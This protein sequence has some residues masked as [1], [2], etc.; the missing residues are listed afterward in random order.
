M[1][2]LTHSTIIWEIFRLTRIFD[3]DLWCPRRRNLLRHFLVRIWSQE[4]SSDWIGL[5]LLQTLESDVIW[6]KCS[7]WESF[8]PSRLGK[9]WGSPRFSWF[10]VVNISLLKPNFFM[11]RD[12]LSRWV[13]CW[14]APDRENFDDMKFF[15]VHIFFP[16]RHK[17]L[18]H[19]LQCH[20]QSFYWKS[21]G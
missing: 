13:F 4:G 3:K 10:E 12:F 17:V 6:I 15:N 14:D 1:S 19:R 5:F 9:C 7:S 8:L 16:W 21:C 18:I 20:F 11:A 2:R